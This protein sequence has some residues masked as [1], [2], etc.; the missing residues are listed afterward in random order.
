MIGRPFAPVGRT[1]LNPPP[2]IGVDP[3]AILVPA[4]ECNGVNASFVNNS[5]FQSRSAGTLTMSFHCI[6]N[7]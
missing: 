1:Y 2:S 5:N 6:K 4:G 7:L 3:H